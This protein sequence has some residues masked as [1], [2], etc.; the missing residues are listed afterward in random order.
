MLLRIKRAIIKDE[1]TLDKLL[2]LDDVIVQ[3]KIPP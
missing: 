3:E 2:T 1:E